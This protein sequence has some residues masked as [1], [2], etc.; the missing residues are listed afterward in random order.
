MST[1]DVRCFSGHACAIITSFLRLTSFRWFIIFVA[2]KS[3]FFFTQLLFDVYNNLAF[4][5]LLVKHWIIKPLSVFS[6]EVV[7]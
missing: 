7:L 5:S 3:I 6:C 2:P 1:F 4:S